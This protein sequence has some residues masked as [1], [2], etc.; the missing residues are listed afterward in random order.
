VEAGIRNVVA[1][2]W[3]SLADKQIKHLELIAER[4]GVN[5]FLFWYDRDR[6]RARGHEKALEILKAWDNIL[7]EGFDWEMDFPSPALPAA[8]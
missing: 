1:T 7:S 4:T 8:M 6:A 3:W 2:F 5:E